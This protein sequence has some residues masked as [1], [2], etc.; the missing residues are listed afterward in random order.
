MINIGI[1]GGSGY[2]AGELIRILMYHP[3]VNIDF[4]YSTTN[5]GKPL[6]VAHHDL[7]GDIEM[8][9][10][11]T[12]N[13]NVNVV[14]LCL[15]H[16]K[17]ISFLK[18]NQFA[19]HTKI[20]DLGND[21]RLTKDAHFE[22]K[23]FVYGL[24]ELNKSSIKKANY[25]ANPGCF[26]TAIQLALL[27]LAKNNLLK[28]DVH[29]NATTGSTG[30]GVS[31][32]ETSHFSWRNNNMSHYKAFEHQH[33]GEINQSVNQLQADFSDELIFVPNR[34]DFTRGIFA[35]L[36]TTSDES[37]EDL[38]A[39]YEDFYKNEPFVTVTTTNINMKQVVQT[40]KCIISLLKKGNRILITSIIDNLTKGASGQAIQNMNL[41]FGLE[42]TTGLH[43]KPSGF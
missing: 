43:L 12:I 23:E 10:I 1:I 30:A 11:D 38:V 25:I 29:I 35:T 13:P 24:P 15:G 37:L 34:G 4:V 9:F 16:G 8:N 14:F 5:A 22:G 41:M 33:L 28:N 19:S 40:N 26:A 6:S 2:T 18:E 31:L 32:A 39:K 17:S 36:Y 42:E 21:F 27:P 7:M 3:H 20:I